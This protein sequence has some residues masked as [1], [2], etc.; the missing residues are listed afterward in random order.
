MVWSCKLT[1]SQLSRAHF[2]ALSSPARS[3]Q[4]FDSRI[5]VQTRKRTF[6]ACARRLR[7]RG[8]VGVVDLRLGAGAVRQ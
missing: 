6:A 1:P 7:R 3:G 5:T 4:S 2:P 8:G